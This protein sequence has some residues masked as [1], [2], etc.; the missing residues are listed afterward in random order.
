MA[1]VEGPFV[2]DGASA[3]DV[4]RHWQALRAAN[5]AYFDGRIL[6]V[7][8]VHRNGHGGATVHVVECAYRYY[9]VGERGLD[10]GVRPLGV[11]GFTLAGDAVLLGQRAAHVGGYPGCWEFAPGGGLEPGVAPEEMV[12][13]ELFEETGL[14]PSVAP[15][16][17][18]V[19]YDAVMR[20][21]E[22]VYRLRVAGADHPAPTREY[23]ALRWI[24]VRSLLAGERPG[25]LSPIA[26]TMLE[27]LTE[28]P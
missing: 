19:L 17:I 1:S 21:W 12:R 11:K 2:P 22:L 7:L 3:A 26:R 27:L 14:R 4:E 15:V 10:T 23:P 24:A 13:R 9:A 18:A 8:G 16:P 20:T 28:A 6:H 25:T 5:S